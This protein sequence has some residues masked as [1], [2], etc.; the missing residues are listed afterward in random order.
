MPSSVRPCVEAASAAS[1]PPAAQVSTP[2][3]AHASW[4]MRTTSRRMWPRSLT[5]VA[6]GTADV[7]AGSPVDDGPG[8]APGGH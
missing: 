4:Y 3:A 2:R 1:V 7:F 6:H 8:H 5:S